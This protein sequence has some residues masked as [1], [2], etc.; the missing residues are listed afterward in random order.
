MAKFVVALGVLGL[1]A[2]LP[3]FCSRFMGVLPMRARKL[4]FALFFEVALCY[5]LA[6]L[7]LGLVES[8]L[9]GLNYKQGWEFYVVVSCLFVVAGFPG[10]VHHFFWRTPAASQTAQGG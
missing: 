10:F 3:F 5:A 1:L 6:L 2:N 9:E 8:Y 4:G 7:G